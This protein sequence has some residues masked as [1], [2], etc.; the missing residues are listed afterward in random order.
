M[1]RT[2]VLL[3]RGCP[4]KVSVQA[5]LKDE[6]EVRSFQDLEAA[7]EDMGNLRPHG[8][9]VL[10]GELPLDILRSLRGSE[11]A[12]NL[13]M[14]VVGSCPT[15]EEEAEVLRAGAEDFISEDSA[16]EVFRARILTAIRLGHTIRRLEAKLEEM[17]FFVRTITHDL[18]NP[19]GAVL[20]AV[21]LLEVSLEMGDAAEVKELT[22][23]IRR[24]G[25]NAL[26]FVQDLL[27]L[28]RNSAQLRDVSEVPV[29]ELID[30]ALAELSMKIEESG[31][32]VE[33]PDDLP[34]IT[35][36]RR[37]MVQ[38]FTN[39]IGNAIKYVPKGARP[40]VKISWI[41]G[42]HMKAFVI[43]DNGIGIDRKDTKKI[44]KP[45]VRLPEAGEYEG[46]GLGLS[47]VQRIVES[48]EGEVFAM[49][50]KGIGSEFYVVLPTRLSFLPEPAA[51]R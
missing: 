49:S 11:V 27:S 40:Q 18:K 15:P 16:P 7:L 5:I 4:R 33:V 2:L 47:I 24:S 22:G 25:Q 19:I 20:A 10:D 13:P 46:N 48:H 51:Q 32:A 29:R 36:D 37:R 42:P 50:R 14:V 35:C 43:G 28:L 21:D 12:R 44:F 31:A 17:D 6:F 30:A 9:I 8:I 38:V 39:I 41:D 1:P 23:A 26:D 34:S 45:F 3:D